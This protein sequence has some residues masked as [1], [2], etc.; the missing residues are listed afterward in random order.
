MKGTGDIMYSVLLVDDEALAREAI[1]TNMKWSELGYNL[2]GTCKNGKE[3][4]EFLKNNSIDV[5][6]TDI[7]MPFV[8]GLELSKHIFEYYTETRVIILSGYNEFE[9]AKMAVKYRVIEYVLKPVT[10]SELSDILINLKAS[11]M[12]EKIKKDSLKK[13]T[14]EYNKNLPLLRTRYLN[15]MIRGINKERTEEEIANKLRELNVSILG[16]YYKVA[17]VVVENSEEF[18]E[19]TPEAKNDLPS[20]IIYNILEEMV[21]HDNNT[22][23]FQDI[24]NDT[25]II[26]GY[27]T[28]EEQRQK[29]SQIF[30][31]CK[32]MVEHFFSLGIT[33]GIGNKVTSLGKINKA[34]ESALS[35]LEYR[36][37]YGGNKI[38]DIRD[39]GGMDKIKT[40]DIS[41][42]IKKLAIAVKINHKKDI[43]SNLNDIIVLLRKFNMSSN[44]IY[45]NIQMII[46]ALSN[47]LESANLTEDKLNKRQEEILQLL[48]SKKT[49]DE[50]EEIL[51]N[52]CLYIG[53]VL[54][55]QRD[56]FSNKQA[57]IALD[58]I[59]ENYA[60]ADLTLQTICYELS[61]SVSYF[62]TIFKKYTGETFIEALTKKRIKKSMELLTNTTMKM[63]EIAEKVG[64]NDPHY[65]A[66]TFKKLT[67]MTPKEY[68][69]VGRNN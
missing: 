60:N 1:S 16:N 11:L 49:L 45:I 17:I 63:Y 65:F 22:I 43:S 55:E 15:Q 38:L 31:K 58:Y 27:E 57:I 33:F 42:N 50:V 32:T 21:E 8:D 68:A 12:E 54:S 62:S 48:Y 20:F 44:R 56:S 6:I 64:Y 53:D 23:V 2:M 67:G 69:K 59:E 5:V 29:F 28:E 41:D 25:V 47:L 9:Y 30:E 7:C 52:Y 34:F 61:I 40:L 18:L 14:G 66:I 51:R 4:I 19:L 13:L 24:N 39:F 26:L 46:V 37:L 3:A 35:S 36:F 10:A